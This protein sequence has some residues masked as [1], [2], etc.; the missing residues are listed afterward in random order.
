MYWTPCR[1]QLVCCIDDKPTNAFGIIELVRGRIYTVR[2]VV[3]P[4]ELI[5]FYLGGDPDEP[6][7]MLDEVRRPI[8]DAEYGEVS[9]R[10][11]RF[12]PVDPKQIAIFRQQ[13]A[14]VDRVPA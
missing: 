14:P 6:G 4:D 7:I 3:E 2:Q 5:A 12:R 13:I 8:E 1:G 11:S 9:F 10:L